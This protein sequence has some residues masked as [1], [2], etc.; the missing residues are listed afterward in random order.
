MQRPRITQI[1]VV[2]AAFLLIALAM[3]VG[4]PAWAQ[5]RDSRLADSQ[6][7]G[8]VIVFPKFI[9]GTVF[10]DGVPTPQTEFELGVVC[11]RNANGT[12]GQCTE[13]LRIKLR[14]HYVCGTRESNIVFDSGICREQ[15]FEAT[16]TVNGK[17]L[18]N[19]NGITPGNFIT[20]VAPCDRGYLIAW[21]ISPTN[22]QPIKFDGLIGSAVVRESG[23]AVSAYNAIPIQAHPDLVTNAA[24]QTGG[25]GALFF[26]GAPGHYQAITGKIF[27]DVLYDR[28]LASSRLILLT[29]DVRSNRPN[30]PT[31]VDFNFY[32]AQE[33]LLSVP[34]VEFV[35]W[36]EVALADIDGNLTG[37]LMGSRKGVF[38][39]DSV[40][41][42]PIFGINDT[43][44]PVTLLGLV[45]T[46]EGQT[47]TDRSYIT[48]V[49][50][51]STVVETIFRP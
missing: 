25:A 3:A 27:G 44:G 14:F 45:Q 10:P 15:D 36:T 40:E 5:P 4:S 49:F 19:P 30:Y 47:G 32:N 1:T 2:G 16:V 35:C 18:F 43:A 34:V 26:D 12:P 39:S 8:S 28:P 42:V 13:G 9:K 6:E 38:I 51:D 31:F 20:P 41:K 23:T 37:T 17:L 48:G 33:A 29:L 50:N 22:D 21:V 7:P 11:P 46:N 24:I